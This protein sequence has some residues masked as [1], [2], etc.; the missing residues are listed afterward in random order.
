MASISPIKAC[1]YVNRFYAAAVNKTN[2]M[3]LNSV[4]ETSASVFFFTFDQKYKVHFKCPT[5]KKICNRAGD[6]NDRSFVVRCTSSIEVTVP[7]S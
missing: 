7:A 4:S 5:R 6:S 2:F 3:S 1:Q